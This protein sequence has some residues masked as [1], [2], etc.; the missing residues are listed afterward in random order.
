[1]QPALLK[2]GPTVPI[3]C[4]PPFS[5][6][7]QDAI[8]K[9]FCSRGSSLCTDN[10]ICVR[11][12]R[13]TGICCEPGSMSPCCS[14]VVAHKTCEAIYSDSAN[15]PEVLCPS[16][17]GYFDPCCGTTGVQ[18]GPTGDFTLELKTLTEELTPVQVQLLKERFTTQSVRPD[19]EVSA[20][21]APKFDLPVAI[22]SDCITNSTPSAVD[23]QPR[24]E[25]NDHVA[26]IA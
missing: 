1:M 14:H 3:E 25:D 11:Q 15:R 20:T 7:V 5:Y 2:I 23:A 10:P 17:T 12:G 24:V 19:F 8:G 16:A 18:D 6:R 21:C 4:T 13:N 9:E 26:I 22:R